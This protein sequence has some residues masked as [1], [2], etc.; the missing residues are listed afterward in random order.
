MKIDTYTKVLLT[1]I[2]LFLGMMVFEIKP[3]M[4]AEAGLM[5]GGEMISATT[6]GGVIAHLRD[7]EIRICTA[8]GYLSGDGW[9]L[10]TPAECSPWLKN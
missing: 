2:F 9:N 4:K 7:G 1:G 6:K 3:I 5:G 10:S 8:G